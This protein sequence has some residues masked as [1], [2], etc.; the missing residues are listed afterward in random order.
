[1]VLR[2]VD[3]RQLTE[4]PKQDGEHMNDDNVD[5]LPPELVTARDAAIA[6]GYGQGSLPKDADE[7]FN[8]L[9]WQANANDLDDPCFSLDRLDLDDEEARAELELADDEELSDQQR[10]EY[11]RGQLERIWR[12]DDI[13]FAHAYRIE[14]QDGRFTYLCG[15]SWAGGQGGPE[16]NC[17]GTYPSKEAYL[18]SLEERGMSNETAETISLETV[19]KH[20]RR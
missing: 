17:D 13:N 12:N 10:L 11:A 9:F 2:P 3:D 20:W 14:G 15:T 16:T 6:S 19:L 8:W 1:M 18:R 7:L 5:E 4:L